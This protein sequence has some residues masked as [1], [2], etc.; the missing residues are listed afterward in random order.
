MESKTM[1]LHMPPALFVVAAL[2]CATAPSGSTPREDRT[3][4][5]TLESTQGA[6]GMVVLRPDLS[7]VSESVDLSA[8]L[9][10]DALPKAYNALT[11]PTT[12]V[13]NA[14][15]SISG[16]AT[17]NR[18]YLRRS[19]SQYLDCGSSIT[20]SNADSYPVRLSLQSRVDSLAPGTSRLHTRLEAI[21]ST[22]SGTKRC[23]SSGVLEHLIAAQVKEQLG[24][25]R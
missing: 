14:K 15:R 7:G 2:A 3:Q 23:S 19:V 8:Q 9:V 16:E 25:Q 18:Q 1:I 21:A 20:G 17:A 5:I 13:D 10:W 11:I 24:Y 12:S 4:T 22:N 6:A